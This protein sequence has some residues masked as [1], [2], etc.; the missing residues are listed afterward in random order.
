VGFGIG[1]A[2]YQPRINELEN[3]ASILQSS[4]VK[5]QQDL[6]S[7]EEKVR[8]LNENITAV[9]R[10]LQSQSERIASIHKIILKLENDRLLLI[11]LMK[12]VPQ[13]RA[14]AIEFWKNMKPIAVKSDPSL[15]PA[16]DKILSWADVYFDWLDKSPPSGASCEKILEWFSEYWRSGADNYSSAIDDF[17]N[18]ALS[19]VTTHIDVAMSL[20]ET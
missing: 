18:A 17:R 15:G 5:S 7:A 9:T 11:E 10:R 16:I 14:A 19:V 4:L 3:Q 20:I 2:L 13:E 6:N 1:Y 12:D 8:S